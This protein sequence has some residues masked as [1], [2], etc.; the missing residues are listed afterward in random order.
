MA[1][2]MPIIST[3]GDDTVPDLIDGNGY[4]LKSFGDKAEIKKI[5]KSFLAQSDAAKT[6][7]AIRSEEILRAKATL[8]NMTNQHIIGLERAIKKLYGN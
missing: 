7:M 2:C 8:D 5:I 1:Y 3:T 6:A 4:L